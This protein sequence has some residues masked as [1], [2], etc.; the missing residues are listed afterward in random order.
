VPYPKNFLNPIAF[1]INFQDVEGLKNSL[2]EVMQQLCE[3][4]TGS[5]VSS[6]KMNSF[7]FHLQYNSLSIQCYKYTDHTTFH[8]IIKEVYNKLIER[9]TINPIRISL[10]YTNKIS[11]PTGG[12]FEFEDLINDSL[13]KPT[14]EFKED[15]LRRSFGYM[16]LQ[17]PDDSIGLNFYYGFFNPEYPNLIAKREF[18]LD[19]DCYYNINKEES[20]NIDDKLMALR[21]KVNTYFEKSIKPNFRTNH[22]QNV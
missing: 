19:Y 4:K 11:F 12:A 15:H 5:P 17:N 9:Y 3:Q 1:Q 8:P 7:T 21:N 10:R 6:P 18:L 2:D 22:L 14:L 16:E 20:L 13:L